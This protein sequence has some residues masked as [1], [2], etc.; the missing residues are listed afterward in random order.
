M[1]LAPDEIGREDSMKKDLNKPLYADYRKQTAMR[2]F[3]G[4]PVISGEKSYLLADMPLVAIGR[5]LI[6]LAVVLIGWS[7]PYSRSNTIETVIISSIVYIIVMSLYKYIFVY[8][9]GR[10]RITWKD[11]AWHPDEEA[12]SRC[13][14]DGKF[15]NIEENRKA[16]KKS[17]RAFLV[18]CAG[19]T[20]A[21]LLYCFLWVGL[22]YLR[23]YSWH[24]G[25]IEE[26][27]KIA[28]KYNTNVG[29]VTIFSGKTQSGEDISDE[30]RQRLPEIYYSLERD[31]VSDFIC[32]NSNGDIQIGIDT[33]FGH[34]KLFWYDDNAAAYA[35]AWEADPSYAV[36]QLD[37]H[38]VYVRMKDGR[39][40]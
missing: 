32:W 9:F 31:Y 15:L 4:T 13:G 36:I 19:I 21:V 27:K 11:A 37:E 3:W 30:N 23:V 7:N 14:K 40:F 5:V 16:G 20:A 25:E 1:V 29:T 17:R 2:L 28:Q 12:D 10:F 18:L 33:I 8:R 35:L 24:S 6:I 22:S 34:S 39:F 26:I 38:W